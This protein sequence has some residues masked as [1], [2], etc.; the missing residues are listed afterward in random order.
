MLRYLIPAFL[1]ALALAFPAA[2]A[3]V[4]TGHVKLEL[5][6]ESATVAPGS[7]THVA[8][9]QQIAPGWHTYW[10]NAGD[11]GLPPE[12]TWTLPADWKAG[13]IVWPAPKRLP[14]PPLMTYGY[15]SEVLLPVA[16]TVPASARPGERAHLSAAV[17][18]LVCADVCIPES[19]TVE[20][21]LPIAAAAPQPHPVFG[22][23][24]ASALAAAPK[25]APIE[26][27]YRREN[28]KLLLAMT[29]GPLKGAEAAGAYFFPATP[30]LI[31]YSAA[32]VIE[33]GPDGL[34]LTLTPA[35]GS[36]APPSGPIAGVL[37]TRAGAWEITASEGPAPAGAGGLGRAPGAETV[38]ALSSPAVGPGLGLAVLFG[39]L[40]GLLLNLMPC[41]F[42]VLAM[43]AAALARGAHDPAT[44]RRDG[45]A[46]L[47][48][49]LIAFLS[50][51]AI[52][53]AGKAAGQAV[54]WG[55]QLQS[56]AVT[57]FLAMLIAAIGL[58]LSGVYDAG[59]SLQG[60]GAGLHSRPGPLGA[61]FAGVLAV[62]IGA[63]CT[64]PF[65]GVALGWALTAGTL[66]TLLV[67]LALGLGLALPYVVLS[68]S[69]GALDRLPRPGP[70]MDSLRRWLAWPM[71]GTCAFLVWVFAQQS[72]SAALG[73]L[74]TALLFLALC[75][76]V[77]GRLQR[78][79]PEGRRTVLTLVAAGLALMLA[80][81][82]AIWGAAAPPPPQGGRTLEGAELGAEPWSQ[83]RQDALIAEGRPVF[84]NFTA[85]WCVSCKVNEQTSLSRPE[86]A[87]ALRATNTAYLVAD[88][89]RRDDAIARALAAQGRSGV[90]LYVVY[91]PGAPAKVL[92]QILTA[93]TVVKAL[94]N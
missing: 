37:T 68:F 80:V 34:T 47:G 22:A 70:W 3:P 29:G 21:D 71:Y 86:V 19:G 25:T 18:L 53:I 78:R 59:T 52:L 30:R 14:Q 48:G 85:A 82:F 49:V 87:A 88:W 44:T 56:P 31:D 38:S 7:T 28:G 9:R 84:V 43:K 39:L 33:R 24:V 63:P 4:N 64:A 90:P 40:G 69:P 76:Q 8:L 60:L 83:A 72:G 93:G 55:F 12:L 54:G 50:L 17:N 27:R 6:P 58:N 92:P 1:A 57:A 89:T 66:D 61:F 2:A 11:A 16:I 45:L 36:G 42:P 75:L 15:E 91:R 5:A 77:W 67:F 51:G 81:L 73:F 23:A 79:D 94:K 13:E 62:V 32:Q 26:A 65:M 35:P 46:F 41:V 10:K 20:I 74:L